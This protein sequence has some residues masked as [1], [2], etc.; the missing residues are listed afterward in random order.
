MKKSTTEIAIE[1]FKSG[2]NCAQAVFTCFSENLGY[3]KELAVRTACGFGG[4]M[5]RLGETCGAV[6]G[7]YMVL[8]MINSKKFSD[9]NDRKEAT[10]T[11]VRRFTEKFKAINGSA[12]CRSL[13]NCEIG[14]EEGYRFAVETNLFEKVCEKCIIDSIRIIEELR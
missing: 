11:M 4:G 12:E 6:T 13:I 10:Y 3:D 14:T 9:N 5:G 2:M 8:G 7:S 1:S